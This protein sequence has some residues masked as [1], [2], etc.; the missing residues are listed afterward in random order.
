M[1]KNLIIPLAAMTLLYLGCSKSKNSDNG[2]QNNTP[3]PIK[4]EIVSGSGQ[5]DTVGLSLASPIVIKVTQN[6]SPVVGY[7]VEFQASGCNR[8]L[9]LNAITQADGTAGYLWRLAGD[10]G[11]QT[12]KAYA[13]NAKGQKVDSASATSTAIA[14][15]SGWQYGA[16]AFQ[17]GAPVLAF[18]KISTGRIFVCYGGKSYIRYSDDNGA[19]WLALSSPGNTHQWSWILSSPT[20]ELFAFAAREGTFY[21]KDAG[22]TWTQLS[23]PPFNLESINTGICTPGGKLVVTTKNDV[24]VSADKGQTWTKTAFT[25]FNPPN[26]SGGDEDFASPAEDQSGNLYVA[27]RESG[28]IYQSN[29]NGKTWLPVAKKTFS[30]LDFG[31][32]VDSNNWFYESRW[33][34][35]GG[36]YI[37]KDQGATYSQVVN[38]PNTFLDL[39]SIQSDGKYYYEYGPVG[40]YQT[41]NLAVHARIIHDFATPQPAPYIVA[42]N[43]NVLIAYN[44]DMFILYLQK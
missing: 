26:T 35:N 39:F 29:D 31:L 23:T 22:Q 17:G 37:S 13:I 36:I 12:L 10:V 44:N 5:T 42:N 7:G 27:G 14:A 19:S 25:G 9:V 20:D 1:T 21:S 33:D 8:D 15:P 32:Y 18:C 38:A 11:Q 3:A 34:S 16:C 24:S 30:E 4:I 41:S 28:T 43:G 2:P 40:L 6:G